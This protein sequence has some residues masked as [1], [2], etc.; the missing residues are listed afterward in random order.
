LHEEGVLDQRHHSFPSVLSDYEDAYRLFDWLNARFN[1]DLF[2]GKGETPAERAQGWKAEK[3]VVAARHLSLLA[4]FVSGDLHMPSGQACLWPQYAFDVIPLEFISSIYETF[5]TKRAA[6]QGIFYTPP[7][8]VDFV[9]DR[10][11]RWDDDVWDL[12][13]LDPACGSGIFLVKAFQRLVHRWKRAH[14]DKQIRAETLRRL[15]E[16][17]LFGVDK[18]PHA[19]RVACF[20]LYLAM[21]G[22]TRGHSALF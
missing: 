21:S 18:D 6:R 9:L 17:N 22:L 7:Y 11:L 13:I 1:G 5:V 2:P 20:S 12:R 16:R 8:L 4:R 10:V 19:A 15:L 3:Q 14:P